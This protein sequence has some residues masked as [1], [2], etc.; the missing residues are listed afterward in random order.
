MAYRA[1]IHG[2]G[3]GVHG[4]KTTTGAVCIGSLPEA[5]TAGR[6]VLRLGDVTTPCP[7]CGKVGKIAEGDVRA[8]FHGLPVAVNGMSIICGCPPGSNRLIAPLGE[9]LGA[10]APPS[11]PAARKVVQPAVQQAAPSPAPRPL[12]VHHRPQRM[13]HP[14]RPLRRQRP[15]RKRWNACGCQ[16]GFSS[17]S[18]PW[19]TTPRRTCAMATSVRPN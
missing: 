13:S 1:N 7:K 17:R 4:D 14:C 3:Q 16:R 11:G 8:K 6:S 19:T 18:A 15:P 12:Q 2:R 9:W 5:T 10:G